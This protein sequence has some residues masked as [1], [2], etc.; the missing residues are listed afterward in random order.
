MVDTKC[1]T[2]N[3][4]YK[5]LNLKFIFCSVEQYEVFFLWQVLMGILPWEGTAWGLDFMT[6][7]ILCTSTDAEKNHMKENVLRKKK[8]AK[9]FFFLFSFMCHEVLLS[10]NWV[11]GW[12]KGT[13]LIYAG[14]K[15]WFIQN[16]KNDSSSI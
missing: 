1:W 5:P 14:S 12:I 9:I 2:V 16:K 7:E 11:C 4:T 10:Q 3:V 15:M 13:F 6:L 8:E